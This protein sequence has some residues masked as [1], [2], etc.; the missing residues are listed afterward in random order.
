MVD[1]QNAVETTDETPDEKRKRLGRERTR[2]H[3]NRNKPPEEITSFSQI[4]ESWEKNEAA[5]KKA[6]PTLH[7][8]LLASHGAIMGWEAESEEI[9]EGVKDGL[10]AETRS[11]ETADSTEIF[12][13]PDLSF[14]DIKAVASNKG[15]T[16]YRQLEADSIKGSQGDDLEQSYIRYG[17]RLRLSHE[18]LRNA[19][20]NLVLY[21]LRTHDQNLN[22]EIVHEAIADC[23]A[24][25]P[26]FSPNQDELQRLIQEH[27]GA[28]EETAWKLKNA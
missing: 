12:P 23:S 8:H 7:S 1:E 3:R 16:N 6:D 19:R 14:R 9:A 21:A 22:W 18:T 2:K 15:T 10:R 17:F 4:A 24:Y 28:T 25:F 27:R 26:R 20:E 5:L 11:A 13:M